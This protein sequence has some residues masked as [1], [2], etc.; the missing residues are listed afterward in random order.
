[1]GQTLNL[2]VD[3]T[4]DGY[5]EFEFE[6]AGFI[7][8]NRYFVNDWVNLAVNGKGEV[9]AVSIWEKSLRD[10][11]VEGIGSIEIGF[12]RVNV[13][14]GEGVYGSYRELYTELV[15]VLDLRLGKHNSKQLLDENKVFVM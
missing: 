6:V 14:T 11:G 10:L 7:N 15:R 8:T 13:W 9:V 4:K 5:E 2:K 3:L 1:M 12:G